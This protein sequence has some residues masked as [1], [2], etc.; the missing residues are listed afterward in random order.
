MTKKEAR[1]LAAN[2]IKPTKLVQPPVR[3]ELEDTETSD[4]EMEIRIEEQLKSGTPLQLQRKTIKNLLDPREW[5][6][7]AHLCILLV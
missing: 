2:W 6:L 4:I 1:K 5:A 3:I 7:A